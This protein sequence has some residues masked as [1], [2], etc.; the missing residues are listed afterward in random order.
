MDEILRITKPSGELFI[1]LSASLSEDWFHEPSKG[2]CFNE[3]TLQ[4]LFRMPGNVKSNFIKKD[5]LFDELCKEGNELH[6]RLAPA[7]FKSGDN[8]MPWGIW[9]PKYQAVGICKIK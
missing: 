1:T 4:K 3:K 5:D 9:D 8:G 7:Y 6:K 2:W